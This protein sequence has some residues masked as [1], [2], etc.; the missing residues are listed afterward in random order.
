MSVEFRAEDG[1]VL[2]RANGALIRE[3]L[4]VPFSGL[5]GARSV[6]VHGRGGLEATV[7]SV[8]AVKPD[9]DLALL[10]LDQAA[11]LGQP[12]PAAAGYRPN[13]DIWV[14][15]GPSGAS[16]P[17]VAAK[18]HDKFNLRG[19]DFLAIDSGP[20]SAAPV[21]KPDGA[22]LGIAGDLSE[23]RYPIHY[24]VTTASL[25][26][27]VAGI[28]PAV[29]L[30]DA[31]LIPPAPFLAK[32]TPDGLFFRGAVLQK[33]GRTEEARNF[34]NLG[35][36]LAP[37]SPIGYFLLGQILFTEQ[38]WG[39]SAATFLKAA[40]Q[41]SSF[42]MAWHM[43]GAALNQGKRYDDAERIYQQA[44]KANPHSGLTYCSLGG[45]YYNQG[46]WADAAQAFQKSIEM[47]PA[48]W[49]AYFN[50]ALTYRKLNRTTDSE[51]VY[52]ELKEKNPGYAAQLRTA[53]DQPEH[54]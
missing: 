54:P 34:V 8:I 49:L 20:S 11:T 22:L 1:S 12:L 41:D 53:L 48:Y 46:R 10:P 4:L 29:S 9:V 18:L 14:A 30:Q 31:A 25:Q 50:L 42:H 38:A 44:L 43:C 13:S 45:A 37:S 24:V 39:E 27:L 15:Q 6:V 33:L 21:F 23:S 5:K 17:A 2:R 28:G 35:V 32:D 40:Q 36:K 47:D 7:T 16:S 3:G 19:P 51:A 52:L 26:N